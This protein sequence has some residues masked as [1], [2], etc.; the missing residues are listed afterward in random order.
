MVLGNLDWSLTRRRFIFVLQNH[1]SFLENHL[2]LG[3]T[4]LPHT[5]ACWCVPYNSMYMSGNEPFWSALNQ[6]DILMIFSESLAIV[7]EGLKV[8]Q[9]C[10]K[11]HAKNEEAISLLL[12]LVYFFLQNYRKLHFSMMLPDVQRAKN[13]SRH[14]CE[15]R[16]WISKIK[17]SE[18]CE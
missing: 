14:Y 10:T 13:K 8:G 17:Y 6:T 15:C 9:K 7:P 3:T 18:S 11:N 5:N 4:T 2:A 1:A 12:L 16:S